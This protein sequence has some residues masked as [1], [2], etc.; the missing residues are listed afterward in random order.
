MLNNILATARS[1]RKEYYARI[2]GN[3]IRIGVLPSVANALLRRLKAIGANIITV[4]Y[5]RG[6]TYF[7]VKYQ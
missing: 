3:R 2:V 7:Q 1:L 6:Y 5:Y 4:L